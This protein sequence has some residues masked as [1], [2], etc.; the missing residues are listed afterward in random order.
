MDTKKEADEII[1]IL[2]ED[3]EDIVEIPDDDP[4]SLPNKLEKKSNTPVELLIREKSIEILDVPKHFDTIESLKDSSDNELYSSDDEPV[5]NLILKSLIIRC[6]KLTQ[7]EVAMWKKKSVSRTNSDE[8]SF[9]SSTTHS[10][11]NKKSQPKMDKTK[12]NPL[13]LKS[14]VDP[15]SDEEYSSIPITSSTFK[16]QKREFNNNYNDKHKP[17]SNST[18]DKSKTVSNKRRA[19]TSEKDE[20]VV[21]KSKISEPTPKLERKIKF[22]DETPVKAIQKETAKHVE[23][24]KFP[25]FTSASSRINKL[26]PSQKPSMTQRR[27]SHEI[28]NCSNETKTSNSFIKKRR[29]SLASSMIKSGSPLRT[30]PTEPKEMP[31]CRKTIVETRWKELDIFDI[32]SLMRKEKYPVKSNTENQVE[33]KPYEIKK[34]L[35][36]S[37]PYSK[38]KKAEQEVKKVEL[39]TGAVPPERKK[40]IPLELLQPVQEATVVK[41]TNDNTCD[42]KKF[43]CVKVKVTQNTRGNNLTEEFLKQLKQP[44]PRRMSSFNETPSTSVT[45]F[46]EKYA[47]TDAISTPN[48]SKATSYDNYKNIASKEMEQIDFQTEATLDSISVQIN[49]Q[50]QAVHEK[51]A[52]EVS[53][54]TGKEDNSPSPLNEDEISDDDTMDDENNGIGFYTSITGTSDINGSPM[55]DDPRG[56]TK[57][58]NEMNSNRKPEDNIDLEAFPET[59]NLFAS[60]IVV[61]HDINSGALKSILKKFIGSNIGQK[62][63]KRVSFNDYSLNDICYFSNEEIP[64]TCKSVFF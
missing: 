28:K 62:N 41:N 27:S 37:K 20:K 44:P 54:K 47:K 53:I 2:S 36:V 40:N 29:S 61:H 7:E 15:E 33:T 64:L 12:Y 59:V 48:T 31:K 21:K 38:R 10:S 45:S 16:N 60:T 26:L 19:S 58:I 18:K 35:K 23:K 42:H 22:L 34:P 56:K 39:K 13:I 57:W 6:T 46:R 17:P 8:D 1:D 14:I 25:D 63:R 24:I 51:L 32:A 9:G 55:K 4:I 49:K 11:D 52:A 50:M 5:A 30:K 3:D 43:P